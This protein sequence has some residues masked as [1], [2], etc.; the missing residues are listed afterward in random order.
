MNLA[1]LRV[2]GRSAAVEGLLALL[3]C[4]PDVEWKEGEPK[5][6]GGIH[7]Y[8]GFNLTVADAVTS[9]DMMI[10]V[11]RFLMECNA[12]G[13]SFAS[14]EFSVELSIGMTAGGSVQFVAS[15]D[16]TSND[17][18]MMSRLGLD[19]CVIAYPTSDD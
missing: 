6:R 10:A 11:R 17:L 3:Q 18:S 15:V 5:L 19:L 2:K 1:I 13:I 16:L 4:K 12:Q 7:E 14:H 9:G 8:S